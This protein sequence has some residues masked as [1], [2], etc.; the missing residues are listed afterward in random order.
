MIVFLLII[1]FL[2]INSKKKPF[3]NESLND[4]ETFSLA[5]SMITIYCGIFYISDT[6]SEITDSTTPQCKL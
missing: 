5:A 1:V 6:K 4:L 3:V 2:I